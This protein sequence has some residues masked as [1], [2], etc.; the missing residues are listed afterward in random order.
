MWKSSSLRFFFYSIIAYERCVLTMRFGVRKV[1][2]FF[3][4]L[5]IGFVCARKPRYYI[6][7][8][9][10][11]WFSC[12]QDAS[13]HKVPWT[14]FLLLFLSIHSHWRVTIVATATHWDLRLMMSK[15]YSIYYELVLFKI[16]LQSFIHLTKFN[17]FCKWGKIHWENVYL[18]WDQIHKEH[19]IIEH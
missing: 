8:M 15:E 1:F 13:M 10:L 16:D 6:Y 19:I 2:I 5:H 3:Y 12:Y 11:S 7:S 4:S 9:E 17:P 14:N 18:T